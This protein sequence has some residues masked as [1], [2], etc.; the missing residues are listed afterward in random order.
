MSLSMLLIF[1]T[2][3]FYYFSFH[4][5]GPLASFH[6]ELTS[7]TMSHFIDNLQYSLDGASAHRKV[8]FS[9]REGIYSCLERDSNLGSK[10]RRVI[11]PGR[12]DR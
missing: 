7:E 11:L 1:G 10:Y 6:S 9:H 8:S 5:F 12:L 4:V 2:R 3:I